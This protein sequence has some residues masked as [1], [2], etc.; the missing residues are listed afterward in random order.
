MRRPRDD[1]A[2][3]PSHCVP[4]QPAIRGGGVVFSYYPDEEWLTASR[5][6][7][8]CAADGTA[9]VLAD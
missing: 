4:S 6:L 9:P 3:P 7:G 1:S 5:F 8:G 2:T